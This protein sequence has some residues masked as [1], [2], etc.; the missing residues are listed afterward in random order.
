MLQIYNDYL[1]FKVFVN[2]NWIHLCQSLETLMKPFKFDTL[3]L[4]KSGTGSKDSINFKHPIHHNIKI[5]L[6]SNLL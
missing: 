4:D 6:V 3:F 5:R 1:H 2:S